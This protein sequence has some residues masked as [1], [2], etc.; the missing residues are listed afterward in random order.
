[1]SIARRPMVVGP[2]T[3][4]AE[5]R[6]RQ[7]RVEEAERLLTD[8]GESA[9]ARLCR[10]RLALDRGD[11]ERAADLAERVLRGIEGDRP[12]GRVAALA[13]LVR[14]HT[15]RGAID[16]A[17]SAV[18]RLT[19][20][21][22]LADTTAMRAI[23]SLATGE[24]AAT[25]GN[26][27]RARLLLEDAVDAFDR[28]G[29]RFDAACARIELA[30]ALAAAGRASDA[31]REARA[32]RDFLR[33]LGADVEADRAERLIRRSEPAPGAP[34]GPLSP[35]ERD[36]LGHLANGLTNRA[37]SE[38]LCISQHTVHRHVTSILRKLD[39]PSR[40]A[41]AA[42]AARKGLVDGGRGA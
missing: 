16:D 20:L 33:T 36:V 31:I 24:V 10:A 40:A 3:Q 28:C 30:G 34:S 4:L 25:A 2:T 21:A 27:R 14:A 11:P 23:V 19:E 22:A 42:Y 7:G 41:A 35:R 5:L 32:A 9:A 37:I 8:V 18:Q 17:S 39:L 29:A 6:R 26:L 1:L 15:R 12:L 13:V 38:R